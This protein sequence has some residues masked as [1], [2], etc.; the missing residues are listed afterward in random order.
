ML[1]EFRKR[2]IDKTAGSGLTRH[3]DGLIESFVQRLFTID[4]FDGLPLLSFFWNV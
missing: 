1:R 4:A 3:L 2:C